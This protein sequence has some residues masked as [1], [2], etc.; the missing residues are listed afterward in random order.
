MVSVLLL[1]EISSPIFRSIP[2]KFIRAYLRFRQGARRRKS[3][4]KTLHLI[5]QNDIFNIQIRLYS[6]KYTNNNIPGNNSDEFFVSISILR[7]KTAL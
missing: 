1:V 2:Q 4:V 5:L 3:R 7:Q 6:I